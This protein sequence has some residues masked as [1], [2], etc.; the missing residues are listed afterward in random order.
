M[1]KLIPL[2][3]AESK[4]MNTSDAI[5]KAIEG[6]YRNYDPMV[7]D[8]SNRYINMIG[9]GIFLDKEF[10]KCLGVAEGWGEETDIYRG[11]DFVGPEWIYYWHQFI[12]VLASGK[13]P[14]EFF[15]KL[16]K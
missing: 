4:Y 5:K 1:K 6:G 2:K 15:S 10:W 3:Q 8:G 16:L 7:N 9:D 14:D 12:D 13:T 11:Q